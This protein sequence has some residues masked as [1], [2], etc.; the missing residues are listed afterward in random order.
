VNEAARGWFDSPA[1]REGWLWHLSEKI[2]FNPHD[3]GAM[4]TRF[5]AAQE[6]P[7]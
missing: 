3:F 5:M 7:E 2:W 4:L 1:D 6:A